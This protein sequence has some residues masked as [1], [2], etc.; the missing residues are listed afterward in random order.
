MRIEVELGETEVLLSDFRLWHYCMNYWFLPASKAEDKRFN[1]ELR[2]NALNYYSMKPLPDPV[3]HAR[4]E[5]S[6]ERI[7]D[8]N[9]VGIDKILDENRS[10]QAVFWEL[11]REQVRAVTHF[12]GTCG[13]SK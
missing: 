7:L 12:R 5:Q 13:A 9:F 3:Y 11:R 1:K 6:W 10:I 8:L 4:I 2:N